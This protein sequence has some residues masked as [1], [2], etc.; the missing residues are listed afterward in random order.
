[1]EAVPLAPVDSSS[2]ETTA[3][4]RGG[5]SALEEKGMSEDDGEIVKE[6]AKAARQGGSREDVSDA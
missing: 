1:M 4:A 6:P 2:Q 3:E 5:I